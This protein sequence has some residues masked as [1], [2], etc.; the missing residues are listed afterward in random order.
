MLLRLR[1]QVRTVLSS[2]T[3]IQCNI[4]SRCKKHHGFIILELSINRF[5]V[6]CLD[7]MKC[8]LVANENAEVL[9][10]W[11]DSE[12]EQRIQEQYGVSHEDGERVRVIIHILFG[13]K[14]KSECLALLIR[15][16]LLPFNS[17]LLCH[18]YFFKKDQKRVFQKASG[19][20]DPV[21]S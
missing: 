16:I 19:I 21:I 2:N 8:L 1:S 3:L 5:C 20:K 11:T 14:K 15:L 7:E 9:F 4:Y 17:G 6:A 13:L 12:F 18:K 10:Y